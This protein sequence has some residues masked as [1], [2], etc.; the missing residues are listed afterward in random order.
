LETFTAFDL[1]K[2][3]AKKMKGYFIAISY[4]IVST[5]HDNMYDANQEK[6]IAYNESNLTWRLICKFEIVCVG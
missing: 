6:K 5:F 1:T 4:S 2:K 3:F